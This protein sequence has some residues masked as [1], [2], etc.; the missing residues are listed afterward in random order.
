M[1]RS[2]LLPLSRK[3]Q[4]L[5]RGTPMKILVPDDDVQ[6]TVTAVLDLIRRVSTELAADTSR[7]DGQPPEN[8]RARNRPPVSEPLCL[9]P[10]GSLA[11][12]QLVSQSLHKLCVA[13][14]RSPSYVPS[15]QA[16]RQHGAMDNA[17]DRQEQG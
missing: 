6:A 11:S 14:A 16:A 13:R 3:G 5:W 4:T 9:T 7:K 12:K 10:V 17:R 1:A 15:R 2:L 8:T